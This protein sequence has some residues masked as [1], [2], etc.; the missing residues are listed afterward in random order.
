MNKQTKLD[1]EVKEIVIE[2]RMIHNYLINN[3]CCEVLKIDNESQYNELTETCLLITTE[4][5]MKEIMYDRFKELAR[6]EQDKIIKLK[7]KKFN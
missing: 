2:Y 4:K 7:F 6:K 1:F 3:I 5:K